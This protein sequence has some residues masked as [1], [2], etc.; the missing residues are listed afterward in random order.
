[1]RRRQLAQAL[2]ELREQAGI[3][4]ETVAERLDLSRS[5][6][7]AFESGRN[8]VS[9]PVLETLLRLYGAYEK[10]D[11][12]N[13]LRREAKKPGWWST[14]R[15]PPWL[16]SYVGLE[17]DAQVARAFSLELVPG[18]LQTEEYARQLSSMGKLSGDEIE[19]RVAA[20]LQRQQ[21][22]TDPD[23]LTFS[24]VISEGALRRLLAEPAA[25]AVAQLRHLASSARLSNVRLHVLPFTAG[26]HHSMSGSFTLL[27]FAPGVSLDIAYQEY[28]VG[29]H[30]VDEQ[31]DVRELADVYDQLQ[32][33]A[34]DEE[35][36]LAV[37]SELMESME[38]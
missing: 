34:L 22:L 30:L 37:I 1:V 25:M 27:S 8:L 35:A 29:G 20:R 11:V 14:Y 9:Q 13:E 2:R 7:A 23:P 17:S 38:R 19:R 28:A 21:R 31:D 36:S 16:K 5:A 3:K 24:A 4:V 15:L 10:F 12:L 32:G 18:L 26:L 33:Q 6:I